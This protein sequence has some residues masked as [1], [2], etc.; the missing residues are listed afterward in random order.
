MSLIFLRHLQK[1]LQS[2]W[3]TFYVRTT[4]SKPQ[5]TLESSRMIYLVWKTTWEWWWTYKPFEKSETHCAFAGDFEARC[6]PAFLFAHTAACVCPCRRLMLVSIKSHTFYRAAFFI[7]HTTP[8]LRVC[9]R[10]CVCVCVYTPCWAAL[11]WAPAKFYGNK[12]CLRGAVV[13]SVLWKCYFN[14]L[15]SSSI[16]YSVLL[17]VL[18][19][20]MQQLHSS[21]FQ[22]CCSPSCWIKQAL[23]WSFR[24]FCIILLLFSG[25]EWSLNL[26]TSSVLFLSLV[27]AFIQ[28][29]PREYS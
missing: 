28:Q 4:S 13:G 23:W 14:S 7:K 8:Q 18:L 3:T 24:S 17:F 29:I 16:F 21:L 6:V 27:E 25:V 22:C 26:F 1:D 19:E 20:N 15:L 11:F 5:Y 10:V 2:I 12:L 9:L